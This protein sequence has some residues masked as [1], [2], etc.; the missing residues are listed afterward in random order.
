[1]YVTLQLP[2]DRVQVVELNVP[3]LFVVNVP[4][5]VGVTAPVPEE[6]TTVAVQLVGNGLLASPMPTE[7]G[8]HETVVV[9]DRLVDATVK[10]PLLPV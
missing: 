10:V 1:V 5:P 6:S 4:V 7:G 8:L 3:V 9:V 2:A